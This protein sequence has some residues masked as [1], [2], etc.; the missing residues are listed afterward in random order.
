M[1]TQPGGMRVLMVE[2]DRQVADVLR[3]V[4]AELGHQA[5]LAATTEAGLAALRSEPFDAVILDLHLPQMSGLDLLRA[6]IVRDCDIPVIGLSGVATEAEVRASVQLGATDLVQKP[7]PLD[8]MREVLDYVRV[9]RTGQNS[10]ADRRR[11]PRPE[12]VLPVRIVEYDRPMWQATSVDLSVFGI[13]L[14][15]QA[16]R[17]RGQLVKLYFTP[18]D[19]GPELEVYALPVWRAAET[20][21][22]RF[23]N[24]SATNYERLRRLVWR[25]AA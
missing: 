15:G 17:G 3:D 19:G 2:G 10:G 1:G 12:L 13:R 25:L 5:C 8:L 21:A 9:Q 14:R 24:L 20:H 22:F 4:L 18:P 23:A 16:P 6:G 11:S 7:A